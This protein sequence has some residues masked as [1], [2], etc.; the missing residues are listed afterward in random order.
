MASSLE[1]CTVYTS[2]LSLNSRLLHKSLRVEYH[3]FSLAM[4]FNLLLSCTLLI[5]RK[6]KNHV[7]LSKSVL[8]YPEQTWC[9]SSGCGVKNADDGHGC[10]GRTRKYYV[11]CSKSDVSSNLKS[12]KSQKERL[13]Q[14]CALQH[15]SSTRFKCAS[16]R[17]CACC[18]RPAHGNRRPFIFCI[19]QQHSSSTGQKLSS[20]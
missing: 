18:E 8:S 15:S 6:W 4:C 9:V 20:R 12:A 3:W 2:G 17:L 16:S 10:L 5:Q 11:Y 14:N 7:P 13:C 19:L 1:C